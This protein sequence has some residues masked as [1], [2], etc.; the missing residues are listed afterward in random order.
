MIATFIGNP[1]DA[2]DSTSSCTIFGV[3]FPLNVPIRLPET[4]TAAQ[5][6]KLAIN[7]HFVVDDE[8]S[9]AEGPLSEPTPETVTA[10]V[11]VRKAAKSAE[12]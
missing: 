1:N 6:K 4:V 2:K 11:R 9:P 5:R 8:T 10:A 12:A 7:N 3:H